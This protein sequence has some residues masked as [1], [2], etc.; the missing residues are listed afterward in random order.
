MLRGRIRMFGNR[1]VV[2]LTKSRYVARV[3]PSHALVCLPHGSG[4]DMLDSLVLEL[5]AG[6]A[7]LLRSGA[8]S[9]MGFPPA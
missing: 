4:R 6:T 9:D 8:T 2:L 5:T 1:M 7:R 3:E